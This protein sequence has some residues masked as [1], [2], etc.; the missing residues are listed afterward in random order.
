MR[1][2][3]SR[4][5]LMNIF[6]DEGWWRLMSDEGRSWWEFMLWVDES[7]LGFIRGWGLRFDKGCLEFVRFEERCWGLMKGDEDLWEWMKCES[8]FVRDGVFYDCCISWFYDFKSCCLDCL[9]VV[10]LFIFESCFF[11]FL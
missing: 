5:G 4:C 9:F 11:F 6:I 7:C 2:D 3:E 1:I 8:L 10:L